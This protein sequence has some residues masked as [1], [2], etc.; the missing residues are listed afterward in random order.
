M[1]RAT[2]I[3]RARVSYVGHLRRAERRGDY[4]RSIV[5]EAGV[6]GSGNVLHRGRVVGAF[7]TLGDGLVD[8][9]GNAAAIEDR[10]AIVRFFERAAATA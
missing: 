5:P 1:S 3:E 2:I 10:D 9:R 8:R 7:T 6:T 4:L